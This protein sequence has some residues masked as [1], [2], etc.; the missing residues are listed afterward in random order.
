MAFL[1][2]P[3]PPYGALVFLC[4][5]R[6]SLGLRPPPSATF[7]HNQSASKGNRKANFP[8][9][10]TLVHINPQPSSRFLRPLRPRTHP[11]HHT[12]TRGPV[13]G[14]PPT[15]TR[16]FPCPCLN[17]LPSRSP[18]PLGPAA[19]IIIMPLAPPDLL[20]QPRQL[21]L[22]PRHLVL[23]RRLRSLIALTE[24]EEAV[25]ALCVCFHARGLLLLPGEMRE[26]G[27]GGVCGELS[28]RLDWDWGCDGKTAW[29]VYR[30]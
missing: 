10:S 15:R 5:L 2:Q 14:L 1:H 8:Q 28:R 22:Q 26:A 11:L 16:Q 9:L 20:R 18:T 24:A 7:L 19:G 3:P 4:A 25:E 27:W 21:P 30:L 6:N 17:T 12:P 13:N 23:G 29:D